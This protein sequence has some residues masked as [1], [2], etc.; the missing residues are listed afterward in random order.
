MVTLAGLSL[1]VA[2]DAC[3]VVTLLSVCTPSPPRPI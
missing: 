3:V 2:L 1:M